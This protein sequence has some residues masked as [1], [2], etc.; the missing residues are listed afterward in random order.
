M[1][2]VEKEPSAVINLVAYADDKIAMCIELFHNLL[3]ELQ[4]GLGFDFE[5]EQYWVFLDMIQA[6]LNFNV[7]ERLGD[8]NV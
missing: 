7:R 6:E 4:P 5:C 2:K 1:E 3:K 8:R